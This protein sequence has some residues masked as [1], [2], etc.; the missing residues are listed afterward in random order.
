MNS[1]VT[2]I[3]PAAVAVSLILTMV[4]CSSGRH[5]VARP[6]AHAVEIPL[7]RL[8]GAGSV[9]TEP[10]HDLSDRARSVIEYAQTWLGTPYRYGG[11]SRKGVD[12]SALVMSVYR[13]AL[14]VK[15]PRTTVQQ[16]K[17]TAD[18]RRGDLRPGDLIFFSSDKNRNGISHVGMFIGND[19]FI[20]ASSSRGV[21]VSKLSE[22]YFVNHYHSSGRVTD[23]GRPGR[24]S[25][26]SFADE[27]YRDSL[28]EAQ[29]ALLDAILTA[30]IDSIYSMPVDD[31]P[32]LAPGL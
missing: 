12:C 20:H 11:E 5:T 7:D 28:M 2:H 22:R 25:D 4:S 23:L 14:G 31:D 9:V 32:N 24:R 15:I 27:L 3:V 1:I 17:F 21:V 13:D 16:R 8:V 30:T 26:D 10:E 19:R 18:V 6:P 29:A